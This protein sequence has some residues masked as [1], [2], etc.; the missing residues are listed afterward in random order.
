MKIQV[1]QLVV[2]Q[3][4]HRVVEDGF[5]VMQLAVDGSADGGGVIEMIPQKGAHQRPGEPNHRDGG[6]R[7]GCESHCSAGGHFSEF[8]YVRCLM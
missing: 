2:D 7:G 4:D 6:G 1:G 5:V 8:A 3:Q